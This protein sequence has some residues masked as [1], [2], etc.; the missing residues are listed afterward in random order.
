MMNSS[1]PAWVSKSVFYQIFPER[2]CNGDPSNDPAGT[3]PW[4]D[5]P[6]LDT[7]FGGDLAG[8]IERLPYLADLEINALY[9]TPI[10]SANT[11]HKY[12]AC[13]YMLIDPAF[14]DLET[15]KKLVKAA[16]QKDIRIVLDAVFNHCGDGFWA[17]Q[18]LLQRG[19]RSKYRDWFI[20]DTFPIVQ[21]PTNYQTCG[22]THY[23]PK[24]NTENNEVRAYFLRV[25]QYWL[26][27]TDI[28]GW[29][30]DVPWKV[31]AD[32]WLEFREVVKRSN[33]DAYIVAEAWRDPAP[34]VNS[35]TSDAIM[36][37]PLC[38]LIFDYCV[39]DRMDAE[40]FYYFTRR[41]LD[42]YGEAAPYQLNLLGSHDTARILT[43]CAGDKARMRLAVI[44]AFTLPGAPM[45]YYGDEIGLSGEND[46]DCRRCMNWSE[47][48]WDEDIHDLYKQLI[49]LRKVH[50]ALQTGSM[51]ALLIFNG[52]FAFQRK[53]APDEMIIVLNPREARQ[54]VHIP[55]PDEYQE[56]VHFKEY[57]SGKIISSQNGQLILDSVAQ[58]SALIFIPVS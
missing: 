9:L 15:F 33:P 20:S 23:L 54:Q 2:F 44:T 53:M 14:G 34:W 38:D 21:K 43:V 12:D 45:I 52:V 11:N 18:D 30:L 31:S 55:L 28:D 25:A 29:R 32:F 37:Y 39:H 36:N 41:L 57:F 49:Q 3:L 42:T 50:P 58:K 10:F 16:H 48:E 51:D 7:F 46:P 5:P 40:D 47:A 24:L 17:F 4:G 6:G 27:E 1:I 56:G 22:G 8:I 19:K 26:E 35:G 13:D